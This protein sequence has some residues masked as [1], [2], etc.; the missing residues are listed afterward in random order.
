MSKLLRADEMESL[1]RSISC[2]SKDKYI[3]DISSILLIGKENLRKLNSI[4]KFENRDAL[5]D[6]IASFDASI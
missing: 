1:I 3:I 6:H 2:P 4:I 5:I